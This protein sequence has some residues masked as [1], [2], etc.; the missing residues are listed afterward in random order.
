MEEIKSHFK[1]DNRGSG[2]SWLII[3]T[4]DTIVSKINHVA[5]I[6]CTMG[7]ISYQG[8]GLNNHNTRY[9]DRGQL[10]LTKVRGLPKNH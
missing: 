10:P 6:S 4:D 8:Y 2:L 3:D 5:C 1:A 9:L 7:D